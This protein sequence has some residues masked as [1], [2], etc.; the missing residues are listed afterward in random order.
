[1]KYKNLIL[2]KNK[3]IK[4][5]WRDVPGFE[6]YYQVSNYG[7][8]RSIDRILYYKSGRKHFRGVMLS[9]QILYNDTE[10]VAL[11]KD[12]IRS[13]YSIKDIVSGTFNDI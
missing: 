12:N 11:Y 13:E 10:I 6:G 5:I 9:P 3:D 4:E 7:R 1:M 2:L 8:V